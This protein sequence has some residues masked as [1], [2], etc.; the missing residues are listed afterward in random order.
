MVQGRAPAP[1]SGA[2]CDREATEQVAG[3]DGVADDVRAG[4]DPHLDAVGGGARGLDGQR[5]AKVEVVARADEGV[6]AGAGAV[7]HVTVVARS[8]GL[9]RGGV[10]GE[11]PLHRFGA[12]APAVVGEGEL[13][14]VG[15]GG[16]G[17]EARVAAQRVRRGDVGARGGEHGVADDVAAD[18]AD[19][20]LGGLAAGLTAWIG[21]RG[22][23]AATERRRLV[24]QGA[25]EFTLGVGGLVLRAAPLGGLC[26]VAGFAGV[27]VEPE[28]GPGG[29][30]G[31]AGHGEVTWRKDHVRSDMVAETGAAGGGGGGRDRERPAIGG[32]AREREQRERED[33]QRA[34]SSHADCEP[35]WSRG[36]KR[37]MLPKMRADGR[38]ANRCF[39]GGMQAG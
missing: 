35:A 15:A 17:G 37:A 12:G 8:G 28:P 1:S 31:G 39:G 18:A 4:R 38:G 34:P 21:L 32:R 27:V 2:H 29:V 6:G 19:P 22:V 36:A 33:G 26:L 24:G 3:G 7:T 25:L 10:L 5:F 14:A 30:R 9:R 13:M 11:G 23:T 20:D 16:R